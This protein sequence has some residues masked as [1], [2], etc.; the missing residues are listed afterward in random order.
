MIADLAP[1]AT[2]RA[3]LLGPAEAAGAEI[4]SHPHPL[5]GPDGGPLATD[6]ARFGAPIGE[7]DTVVLV[8]SGLHGVEGHAGSGLQRLLLDGGRLGTLPD[9]VAVV[10]VHAV[11]PY[12]FAWSRR[13]DHQNIDVNRNFVDYDDLPANPRYGDIDAILNPRELDLD[14]ASF[15]EDL[16]AFWQEVGDDIAFRTISGGQYSHPHGVQFG[17]TGPSW[18]RTT[19]EQVW[20]TH[21]VGAAHAISLDIHT[22]LGPFGRLTVF[23]TADEHEHAAALGAAWF[24]SWLYRS[25]R[26]GSVDHGLLGPGFDE[27]A[28]AGAGRPEVATFV[29][30][31]GTLDPT[32]GVTVFRADNWLHHHGDPDGEVGERIRRQMR[33]FFFAEDPTWRT[34]VADQ[35]LA[36]L[37]AVLDAIERGDHR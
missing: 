14:D 3:D 10:L 2:T 13:V 6:T 26:T 23:Q 25:D 8:S 32:E 15:L 21:L 22:G 18:S 1:Y 36:A 35:G 29:L 37:D 24:P 27:W 11:N 31:F 28:G 9:G 20:A 30:E 7:A 33:D 17:G 19:L 34:D 16:L 4:A 5:V 12:G